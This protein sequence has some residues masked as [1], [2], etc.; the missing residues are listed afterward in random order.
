MYAAPG[1]RGD[2]ERVATLLGQLC[3][4]GDPER[5]SAALVA[6]R[7]KRG[8]CFVDQ[9]HEYLDE[10]I[11]YRRATVEACRRWAERAIEQI[12]AA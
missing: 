7:A 1:Q 10:L 6:F 8:A 9:V 3:R 2:V 11:P 4:L 5:A 12:G